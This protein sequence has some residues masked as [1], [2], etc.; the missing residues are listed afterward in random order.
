[1]KK[2]NKGGSEG[3]V[4]GR[5]KQERRKGLGHAKSKLQNR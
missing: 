3:K 4:D 5:R 1:M 2:L